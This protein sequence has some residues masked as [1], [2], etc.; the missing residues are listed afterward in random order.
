VSFRITPTPNPNSLKISF[1]R[2]L[3]EAGSVTYDS[4]ESAKKDPLARE[5]LRIPGIRSVFVLN[6][7]VT[8]TKEPA[9]SWDAEAIEAA[10]RAH[11]EG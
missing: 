7:F 5:L 2:K 9:S 4:V 11:L 10:V 8:V 3:R 6:D 1:D